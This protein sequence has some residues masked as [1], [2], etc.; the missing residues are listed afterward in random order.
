MP[1]LGQTGKAQ[2]RWAF[3]PLAAAFVCVLSA[4]LLLPRTQFGWLLFWQAVL[5]ALMLLLYRWQGHWQLRQVLAVAMLARVAAACLPVQLSDD[6]YRFIWDGQLMAHGH[7][8]LLSTPDGL[9]PTLHEHRDYFVQLHGLI[10]H[11]QNY[12]CYPPLMQGVFWLSAQLGGYDI[13]ANALVIK[14][15]IALFDGCA[16]LLLIKVLQHLRQPLGWVLLYAFNPAVIIEGSGNAHFEVVQVALVLAAVLAVM[17]QR[18]WVGGLCCGLAVSTKLLPLLLLP[19]W[20]KK[21][22][23]KKGLLFSMIGTTVAA[24]SFAPFVSLGFLKG[25]GQSLNLYF[26]NFE[27]NASLYYIARQIGWWVKGY[28]YISFIGPLLMGIFLALYAVLFFVKKKQDWRGFARMAVTVLALY[29]LLATT[30]HPWYLI[31][32]LPFAL[33]AGLRFPLVWCGVAFLSY[34][35]YRQQGFA[36]NLWWIALEY[37]IVLAAVLVEW[38]QKKVDTAP[39]HE[40]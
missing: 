17:R 14:L 3:W 10:N 36:E 31:N 18:L 30:V 38:R 35:A 21:L 40:M 11:P 32:L 13:M 20:V 37:G 1:E 2:Q 4:S 26:Q 24:L 8:P 28:N 7:N 22:G 16:L 34:H 12:T 19:V 23:W 27:F 9:L 15:C 33:M 5:Y 39:V 25:F 29:Y 6:V